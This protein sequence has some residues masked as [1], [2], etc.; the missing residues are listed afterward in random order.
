MSGWMGVRYLDLDTSRDCSALQGR[1]LDGS[2]ERAMVTD[3]KLGVI[4]RQ[5]CRWW[6]P[7]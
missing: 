6:I 3:E 1:V 2:V 7:S 5:H 4:V